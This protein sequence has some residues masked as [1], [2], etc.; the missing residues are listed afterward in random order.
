VLAD[1]FHDN[2]LTYGDVESVNFWQSIQTPDTVNVT[3][4]YTNSSGVAVTGE[5]VSQ[6]N[7]FGLI[8]DEDATGYAILDRRLVPTQENASGLYRN[9]FLHARQKVFQDLTEKSAVL[10]LD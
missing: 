7:I 1:T 8:F 5:A 2:F 3:P 4:V 9:I 6:G 10:L